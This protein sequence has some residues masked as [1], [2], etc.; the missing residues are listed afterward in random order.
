[1]HDVIYIYKYRYIIL[2]LMIIHILV[3]LMTLLLVLLVL[4]LVLLLLLLLRLLLLTIILIMMIMMITIRIVT[5]VTVSV[6][7]AACGRVY[8]CGTTN[9]QTQALPVRKCWSAHGASPRRHVRTAYTCMLHAHIR[10]LVTQLCIIDRMHQSLQLQSDVWV[11]VVCKLSM[12]PSSPEGSSRITSTQTHGGQQVLRSH[13][14]VTY[15][16]E[17][18]VS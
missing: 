14:V 9:T 8:G 16:Y 18:L 10:Q 5:G 17:L 11:R 1:M 15:Y 12:L 4:V 3:I 6:S 2:L 13:R 7:V